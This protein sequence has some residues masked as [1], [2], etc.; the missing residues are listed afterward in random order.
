MKRTRHLYNTL[1]VAV[2]CIAGFTSCS[3][4][5]EVVSTT[6]L[7]VPAVTENAATVSSLSFSW[8][9]VEGAVQYAYELRDPAGELVIGGVTTTTSLIATGL[10]DNTEYTLTVWAYAAVGSQ[11]GTSPV[12]TITATTNEIVP[13]ATPSGVTS[14]QANASIYITWPEVE[15]ADYYTYTYN[16]GTED[17]SG[18]VY[19]N[20]LTLSGLELGTY[21][22]YI[23]AFSNDEA[24][25]QSETIAFTFERT[26]VEKWR[27]T[28]TYSSVSGNKFEADIV[29]YDDGSY[30]IENFCGTEGYNLE[31]VVNSDAISITNYYNKSGNYYYVSAGTKS[32]TVYYIAAYTTG[33]Y[34]YFGGDSSSG[35]LWFYAYAYNSSGRIG[36]GYDEFTWGNDTGGSIVI[37]DLA[38]SYSEDTYG[39]DKWIY[40]SYWGSS[41]YSFHLTADD[42]YAGPVTIAVTGDDTITLENLY[43]ADEK[44]TGTVDLDARTITFAAGQTFHSYYTFAGSTGSGDAVVATINDDGSISINDWA[45]WYS[46]YSYVYNAYTTLTKE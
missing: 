36:T 2:V 12:A 43:W 9:R 30:A 3:D 10:S 24:Y 33:G 17:V 19:T 34:S 4:D 18:T 8:D 5:D 6:Q 22:V 29:Y 32:S 44:L 7:D 28:G 40:K 46:G 26:K 41:D 35:Y 13:L 20:S 23:T 37:D 31:F 27:S 1:L 45:A 11:I 42:P 14:E 21:T 39:Y 16:N 25:S 38:G 15:N